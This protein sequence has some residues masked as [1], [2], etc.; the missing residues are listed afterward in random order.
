M[1]RFKFS[2]ATLGNNLKPPPEGVS[3]TIVWDTE[4]RGLGAYRG[5][6]GAGTFF[7]HYRVGPRQ[8]KKAIGRINEVTVAEARQQTLELVVAAKQGRDIVEE[9]AKTL[10]KQITL[11]DAYNAYT[12]SLERRHA[13][14][15]TLRL[16]ESNWRAML[17]PY[18]TRELHRITR[19]D[20]R[21]W[22]TS[23]G[24]RGPTR[25]NQ[26]A[27]LLR[28]I[29]NHAYKSV[30]GLPP[31]PCIAIEYFKERE[32]RRIL[33]WE[34]L[35][36]WNAKVEKLSNPIRKAYWRLLLFSG[37]RM[38]DA[39]TIRWKDV[40]DDFLHR[41]NPKGGR[42]KA[43]NLPIT[44]QLRGILDEVRQSSGLL[45]P[46]SEWVFPAESRFGHV[47]NMREKTAFPNV[48]P[49]DIR[50]TYATACAEAGVDPYTIKLLLNHVADGSDVTARYIKPSSSHVTRAA[51]SVADFIEAKLSNS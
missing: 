40:Q 25:A 11:G 45:F 12:Q 29:Y 6:T 19:S 14:S 30:E 24:K 5:R 10:Q 32:T 35:P 43:F 37:L 27:R 48:W 4:T 42:T 22:H 51:Q 50:R 34:E 49:H 21:N 39:A 33:T 8:R 17:L 44:R 28:T 31:N 36:D 23:W 46:G 2:N 47:N 1:K 18:A 9:R 26:G 3:Q 38:T 13:S 7:V 20:V 41:P 15:N 16:N